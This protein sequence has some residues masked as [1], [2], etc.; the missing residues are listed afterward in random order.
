MYV[1][2]VFNVYVKGMN[3]KLIRSILRAIEA[4]T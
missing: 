1:D 2:L 4:I 3:H